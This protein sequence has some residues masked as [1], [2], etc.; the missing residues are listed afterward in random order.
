LDCKCKTKKQKIVNNNL[1][2]KP[3]LLRI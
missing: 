2:N 1:I 3:E